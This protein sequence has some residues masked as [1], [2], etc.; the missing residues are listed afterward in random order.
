M[1]KIVPLE[2]T[3]LFILEMDESPKE[4]V[5]QWPGMQ[6]WLEQVV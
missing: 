2:R 5:G 1:F 4:T 3:G 6:S